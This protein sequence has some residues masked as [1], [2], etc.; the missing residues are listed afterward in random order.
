MLDLFAFSSR[1]AGPNCR[2]RWLRSSQTQPRP[3]RLG[4]LMN[5]RCRR[6]PYGRVPF[7][8]TSY[9]RKNGM[10]ITRRDLLSLAPAALL[11]KDGSRLRGSTRGTKNGWISVRLEGSPADIGYQHG[12]QLSAE[13]DDAVK[14]SKLELRT[15]DQPSVEFLSRCRSGDSVA[16]GRRRVPRRDE[17]HRR[18]RGST[19]HKARPLGHRR[20][21]RQHRIRILRRHARQE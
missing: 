11:A 9:T 5:E 18:R 21:Q 2:G 15:L 6:L 1:P 17:G 13:I 12:Y 20:P 14:V 16:W 3:C 10:S 4:R 7:T 8:I 19:R